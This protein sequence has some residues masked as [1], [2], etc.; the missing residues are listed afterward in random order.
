MIWWWQHVSIFITDQLIMETGSS[1]L[2]HWKTHFWV[3]GAFTLQFRTCSDAFL[4]LS[5]LKSK[6]LKHLFSVCFVFFW[7]FFTSLTTK[8]T[9]SEPSRDC[10]C[11]YRSA[12]GATSYNPVIRWGNSFQGDI[13]ISIT[14][15]ETDAPTHS[16]QLVFTAVCLFECVHYA[17]IYSCT[18][19]CWPA[20]T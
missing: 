3:E 5:S 16:C 12:C 14:C 4:T 20:P 19:R 2:R 15:V 10:L 7:G 9:P 11:D 13:I 6:A 8:S 1:A 17:G 18:S